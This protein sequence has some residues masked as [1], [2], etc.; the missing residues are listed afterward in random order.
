MELLDTLPIH[1]DENESK[2]KIN[3]PSSYPIVSKR[4]KSILLYENNKLSNRY[5]FTF[6]DKESSLLSEVEYCANESC[7]EPV[8]FEYKVLKVFSIISVEGA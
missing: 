2:F 3:Y 1:K 6:L 8:K 4:L 7:L 5:N